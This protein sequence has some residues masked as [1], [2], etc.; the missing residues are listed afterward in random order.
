MTSAMLKSCPG[1]TV[2]GI[3]PSGPHPE[4]TAK[5]ASESQGRTVA[6]LTNGRARQQH[7]IEIDPLDPPALGCAG[8][9]PK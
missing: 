2:P 3:T 8:V 7:S 9:A 4:T 6:T 1:S 5:S